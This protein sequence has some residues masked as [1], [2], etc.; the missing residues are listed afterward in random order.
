MPVRGDGAGGC[1]RSLRLKMSF[2]VEHRDGDELQFIC[3]SRIY[4]CVHEISVLYLFFRSIKVL[5][6]KTLVPGTQLG[7]QAWS[8]QR[9]RDEHA[10]LTA[11][12]GFQHRPATAETAQLMS[13]SS[14]S[15]LFKGFGLAK[16][17]QGICFLRHFPPCSGTTG[18][19]ARFGLCL[20]KA[21][22]KQQRTGTAFSVRGPGRRQELPQPPQPSPGV[23][24]PACS[25]RCWEGRGTWGPACRGQL[26][27]ARGPGTSISP[28]RREPSS[29]SQP[30]AVPELHRSRPAPCSSTASAL[31]GGGSRGNLPQMRHRARKVTAG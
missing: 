19:R 15:S 6:L 21:T 11:L 13:G 3:V 28:A 10:S 25:S 2:A 14:T 8:W 20:S 4:E 24:A 22:T 9:C 7:D 26:Q 5:M 23:A 30:C 16:S 12:G 1:H 18:R 29:S 27:R 17:V 31:G